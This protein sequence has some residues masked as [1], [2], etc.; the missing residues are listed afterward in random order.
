MFL[1]VLECHCQ[2]ELDPHF[3]F[4]YL[5]C[6]GTISFWAS[7]IRIHRIPGSR[8]GP[9]PA[10]DTSTPFSLARQLGYKGER[11]S[12]KQRERSSNSQ[13]KRISIKQWERSSYENGP[14]EWST[15]NFPCP[16]R[17]NLRVCTDGNP[18]EQPA[19]NFCYQKAFTDDIWL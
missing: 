15:T 16:S 5:Q 7:R 19:A 11:T 3:L 6:W 8:S 13:R 18:P 2:K 1:S 4:C 14:P 9:K 12:F 10:A 17:V